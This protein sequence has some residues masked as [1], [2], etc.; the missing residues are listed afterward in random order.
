MDTSY[1]H[2]SMTGDLAACHQRNHGIIAHTSVGL[3]AAIPVLPASHRH[4]SPHRAA[5]Q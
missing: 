4:G 1:Q 2:I 3:R 5:A